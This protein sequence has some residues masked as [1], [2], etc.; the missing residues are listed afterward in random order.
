MKK[1]LLVP[2]CLLF[3]LALASPA[4]A[5]KAPAKG[6][7]AAA[8]YT[9]IK[10]TVVKVELATRT[11]ELKDETGKSFSIAVDPA[12]KDL[13]KVKPGDVV[14][15]TLTQ[16]V[17]Y[18]VKKPGPGAPGGAVTNVEQGKAGEKPSGVRR[19]VT[20]KTVTVTAIN[21]KVPSVTFKT[22]GGEVKTVAVN[23]P[24]NLEG[25]NVGD[26]VEITYTES[27]MFSVEKA[28]AKK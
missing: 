10:A 28:P 20:T 2:S 21:P 26:L 19:T 16:S 11:V 18:E 13:E 17:A 24:A 27:L 23:N 8:E 4:S 7:V 6:G 25:V 22:P 12:L 3:A 5:Q 14:L 15:A 9:M 1:L